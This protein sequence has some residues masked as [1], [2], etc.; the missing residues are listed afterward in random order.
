MRALPRIQNFARYYS[1]NK[2]VL[3]L[4]LVYLLFAYGFRI[5]NYSFT[6][7]SEFAMFVPQMDGWI[8][9]GLR[10]PSFKMEHGLTAA[11]AVYC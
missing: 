8:R 2:L 11:C 9:D 6:I 7:D 4:V 3:A 1:E 5:F 10:H